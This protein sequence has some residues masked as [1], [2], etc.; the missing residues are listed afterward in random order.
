MYETIKLKDKPD[1]IAPDGSEIYL[2][3]R[4]KEG[5]MC[6]CQLPVGMTSVAVCHKTTEE[7]WFF[8]SGKGEV[9]RKYN[10]ENKTTPVEKD[11]AI[12]IPLGCYFQYRN[13]GEESLKFV[14]VGMPPWPGPDE[15]FFVEGNWK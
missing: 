5:S 15:A 8:L 2:L 10:N 1:H 14:I 4:L 12:T 6:V 7:I 3:P 11:V 13:T 9:W